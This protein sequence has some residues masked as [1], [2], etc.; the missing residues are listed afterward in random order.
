[1][2][3]G[4]LAILRLGNMEERRALDFTQHMAEAPY[5]GLVDGFLILNS[6]PEARSYIVLSQPDQKPIIQELGPIPEA[7]AVEAARQ[8]GFEVTW[9]LREAPWLKAKAPQG[10]K[11]EELLSLVESLKLHTVC[12]EALCPNIAECWG[13]G[14][15][16]FMILGDTC[17]RNCRFCSVKAGKPLPPDPQEPERVAEAARKLGLN[18]VVITSVTRDDLPDGGASQFVETIKAV[19]SSLPKAKVEVLIPDF[20]GS[21]KA[22]GK[23]LEAKPDVLNH[24]VETVPRLYPLVRPKADYRRS[25]GILSLAAQAGLTTKSGLMLGL[26]ETRGEVLEVMAELRRAGCQILTIGQYLQPTPKQL[27]VAEYIHPLE[28]EWYSKVGK[29]LG[30]KAVIAGPLVRSSYYKGL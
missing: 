16:T 28:F 20:A 19:R 4:R 10:E 14:T 12:Q 8:F 1:M 30:F 2:V 21:L 22:L 26:G 29:E 13:R 6:H 17:T 15:A 23:V 5:F 18:H 27:P 25:L 9:G 7:E 24:N 11:V 3:K